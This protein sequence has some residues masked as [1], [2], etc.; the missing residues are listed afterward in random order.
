MVPAA[1]PT[2]GGDGSCC[3]DGVRAALPGQHGQAVGMDG[4]AGR[5]R[6]NQDF[7]FL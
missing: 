7:P 2:T 5:Q 1:L 4:P 6:I 3:G